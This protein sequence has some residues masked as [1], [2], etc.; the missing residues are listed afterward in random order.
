VPIDEKYMPESV[1][2]WQQPVDWN[3]NDV[4]DPRYIENRTHYDYWGEGNKIYDYDNFEDRGTLPYT[5]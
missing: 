4:N 2:E 5:F 3:C 1:L